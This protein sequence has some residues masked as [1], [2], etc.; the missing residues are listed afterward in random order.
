[1]KGYC[2]Y[3]EQIDKSQI[4][5][6][7]VEKNKQLID[8]PKFWN[9]HKNKTPHIRAA[10]YEVIEILLQHA[11]HLL[12][13]HESNLVAVVFNNLGDN[14]PA[15]IP[16]VWA[17]I[18]LIQENYENYYN[19]VNLEKSF[20][21]KLWKTL[22]SGGYGCASV[23]FPNLLPLISKLET[24]LQDKSDRFYIEFFENIKAALQSQNVQNSRSD[25][26]AVASAYY[27]CLQYIIIHKKD[28]QFCAELIDKHILNIIEWSLN[29][30]ISNR[31][32]I[33]AQISKLMNYW[34]QFDDN[35][36]YS[37][38]MK[39]IWSVIYDMMSK[40]IRTDTDIEEISEAQ[41]E[42]IMSLKQNMTRKKAGKVKFS[43]EGDDQVD[44]TSTGSLG[45]DPTYEKELNLLVQ[46][47][48]SLYINE[49]ES[50]RKPI[51]IER[52][53]VL[54]ENFG[55]S[56]LYKNINS[57]KS[58]IKLSE[59]ITS[60]LL[61]KKLRIEIVVEILLQ[62]F[63]F[64]EIPGRIELITNLVKFKDEKVQKWIITRILSH[65]L[66]NEN[67]IPKLLALPEVTEYLVKAAKYVTED[68]NSNENLN[69]LHKCFFQMDS[70]DILIDANTS[71]KI[72]DIISIPL[73]SSDMLDVMDVCG[74]FLAQIM[75]V[76]FVDDGKIELQV[77]MFLRL[78]HFSINQ[79]VS[80]VIL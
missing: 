31:K 26:T 23:I 62:I 60:W 51:L 27:E 30:N 40:S 9:F 76:I 69:I 58:I 67:Y 49:I 36:I 74:S 68:V 18:L 75:P 24:L 77:K 35:E 80:V 3:L 5:D 6:E 22:N 34:S 25:V 70:G 21:P 16:H 33:F 47:V 56:D 79:M 73:T 65:P 66:C 44:S 29:S 52:L 71:S 41:I 8:S 50:T 12:D 37:N 45:N 19:H 10:W 4:T 46:N 42:F 2:L 78:F 43:V 15:V 38:F 17:S 39:T 20:Q 61:H 57:E 64:M 54:F 63:K 72:V 55:N 28:D 7:A 14:E 48:S 59:S 11:K 13:K 53:G 1:M 32:Y